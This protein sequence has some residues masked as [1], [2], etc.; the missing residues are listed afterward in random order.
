MIDTAA[1]LSKVRKLL[2]LAE[3]PGATPAEAEAFTAKATRLMAAYGID[4]ALLA[5]AT[6][7]GTQI[8]SRRIHVDA[9]YARDKCSL[10][11]AIALHSRCQAV[12]SR[13]GTEFSM[14]IFG[15]DA[16]L[17]FVEILFTSLLLQ[18]TRDLARAPVPA[19]EHVAAYRRSWWAGFRSAISLR[20]AAVE[21]E[22]V[23]EAERERQPG[24]ASTALVLADQSRA[25]EAAMAQAYPHLRNARRRS[26]TGGGIGDGYASGERANLNAHNNVDASGRGQLTG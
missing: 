22:S 20:L 24:Q 13:R 26:L 17:I 6:P 18:G 5:H 15:T 16:D 12:Q 1:T 7:H 11:A 19:G 21:R 2:A 9:P 10:A 4:Q 14:H 23:Q 25:A 8:A 3:D